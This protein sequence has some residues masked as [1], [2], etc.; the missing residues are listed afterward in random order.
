MKKPENGF[1]NQTITSE[2]TMPNDSTQELFSVRLNRLKQRLKE[3][4]EQTGAKWDA[5]GFQMEKQAQKP[6][7][8]WS[9]KTKKQ[10]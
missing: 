3:I 9:V 8:L 6:W 5:N 7:T 10:P 1:I 2:L 4:N